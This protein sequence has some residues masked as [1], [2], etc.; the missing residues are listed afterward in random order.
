MEST[1]TTSITNRCRQRVAS[2][3]DSP[4][5][6]KRYQVIPPVYDREINLYTVNHVT[7]SS[8]A[9]RGELS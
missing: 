7:H 6:L 4:P 2:T 5:K 8:I 3:W 9:K 1:E